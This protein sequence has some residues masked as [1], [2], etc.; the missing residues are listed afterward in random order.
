MST[1]CCHLASRLQ[2]VSPAVEVALWV[3]KS[4][5]EAVSWVRRHVAASLPHTQV[6]VEVFDFAGQKESVPRG[7]MSGTIRQRRLESFG[8]V[9]IA[10]L[11]ERLPL[12]KT[13]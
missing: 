5:G 11:N 2:V 1:S 7:T 6:A 13:A 12:E 3:G 4:A 9:E 8:Q 10:S